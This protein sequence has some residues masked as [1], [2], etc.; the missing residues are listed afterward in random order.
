MEPARS[1]SPGRQPAVGSRSRWCVAVALGLATLLSVAAAAAVGAPAYAP[2]SVPHGELRP[3]QGQWVLSLQG[4]AADRGR[5]AGTLL[6]PQIRWLLPRYLKA[7]FGVERVPARLAPALRA[8][9]EGIPAAHRR[10]LEAMA[11]AAGVDEGALLVANLPTELREGLGC[12]SAGVGRLRSPDGTV[13]L[14]RNLDWQGGELLAPLGLV[15]VEAGVGVHPFV[16][17]TWPG[18]VGVVTGIN[19]EG[20]TVANLVALGQRGDPRGRTPV[21][22]AVR[23]ALERDA[24]VQQALARLRATPAGTPQ[25]F[26]LADPHEAVA[27]ERAAGHFLV[28]APEGGLALVSNYWGEDRG[29]ATD[30]R[31]PRLRAALAAGPVGVERLQQVLGAVAM[32][33]RNLQAVVLEPATRRAWLAW[34]QL[35]AAQGPYRALELSWWLGAHAAGQRRGGTHEGAREPLISP[36]AP[37][38]PL[39]GRP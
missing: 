30:G 4:A 5:A 20:L 9:A 29:A 11:S 33:R 27:L 3:A 36:A 7:A 16:S 37:A 34:G 10:Q 38:A 1:L 12:T 8:L 24:T 21:L 19:A 35:P 2:G 22:F 13:R 31:Y 32:G 15:V 14:A 39:P 28:R 18:L 17:F 6:G 23:A 26:A 25:S